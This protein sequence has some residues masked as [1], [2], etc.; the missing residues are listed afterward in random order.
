MKGLVVLL[1][2]GVLGGGVWYFLL[3]DS[4][5]MDPKEQR[6]VLLEEDRSV[7]ESEASPERLSA[8]IIRLGRLGE[9]AAFSTALKY[10]E[11]ESIEVR[12]AVAEALGYFKGKD[13]AASALKELLSDSEKLVRTAALRSVGVLGRRDLLGTYSLE[14]KSVQEKIAYHSSLIKI[15][16]SAQRSQSVKALLALAASKGRSSDLAIQ[17]VQSVAPRHPEVMSFSRAV[18]RD[19]GS[20]KAQVSS[21]WHLAQIRDSWVKANVKEF[22]NHSSRELRLAAME[23]IRYTCPENRWEVLE[24]AMVS[25]DLDEVMRAIA[26]SRFLPGQ[27]AVDTLQRVS[28]G[29]KLHDSVRPHVK[30]A[31]EDVQNPRRKNLCLAQ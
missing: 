30:R 29:E 16:S 31:L 8:A 15:G 22:M 11:H 10:I 4:G 9:E 5:P 3:K 20:V 26:A 24:K 2:L 14:K 21:L 25:D 17:E 6:V 12:S 18:L 27:N 23:T 7:L 19:G 13:E 1:L 28:Q